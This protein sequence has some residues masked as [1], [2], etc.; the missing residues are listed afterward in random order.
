MKLV[1]LDENRNRQE[2]LAKKLEEKNHKVVSC[3]NTS[4]FMN[5]LN[6]LS[7]D[8]V[9]IDIESWRRGRSIYS[10]FNVESKLASTPILFCNASEG[11][12]KLSARAQN[13]QDLVLTKPTTE[14]AILKSLEGI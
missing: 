2:L 8:R 13:E 10:F 6:G 4:A 14:E 3:T 5:A 11:F 9:I 7:C 12:T 1:I